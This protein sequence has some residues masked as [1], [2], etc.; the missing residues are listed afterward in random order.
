MLRGLSDVQGSTHTVFSRTHYGSE[1]TGNLPWKNWMPSWAST[2][3]KRV[4]RAEN[5]WL[6]L[7]VQMVNCVV[8]RYWSDRLRE[9]RA[10]RR[11]KE[12]HGEER[13][14]IAALRTH[15]VGACACRFPKLLKNLVAQ[16]QPVQRRR[17]AICDPMP[18]R[19][20]RETVASIRPCPSIIDHVPGLKNRNGLPLIEPNSRLQ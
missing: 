13:C 3:R 11:S 7:E 2:C 14:L 9:T 18:I 12:L 20:L 16:E 5:L 1:N 15:Q 4:I 17:S 10:H 19:I 6:S 8:C